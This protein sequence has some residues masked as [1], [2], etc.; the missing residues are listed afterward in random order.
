MKA[1]LILSDLSEQIHISQ[2]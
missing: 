2:F 1:D